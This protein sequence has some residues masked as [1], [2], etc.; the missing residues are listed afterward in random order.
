MNLKGKSLNT[1]IAQ[2]KAKEFVTDVD[3]SEFED[4]CVTNTHVY[5]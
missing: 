4:W 2:V 1:Y 5:F 3:D